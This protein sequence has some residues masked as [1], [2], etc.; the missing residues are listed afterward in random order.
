M[1]FHANFYS[2]AID[3]SDRVAALDQGIV[4]NGESIV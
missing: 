1:L 4:I 3:S 2:T